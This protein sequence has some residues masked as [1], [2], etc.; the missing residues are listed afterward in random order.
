VTTLAVIVALILAAIGG[1]AIM[2][3]IDGKKAERLK[4]TEGELDAIDQAKQ[5]ENNVAGLSPDAQRE[6]LR[7]WSR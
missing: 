5:A 1:A 2:G 4:R 7:E 3:R 6:R